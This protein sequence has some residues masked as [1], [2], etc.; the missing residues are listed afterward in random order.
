MISKDEIVKILEQEYGVT[1]HRKLSIQKID[2]SIFVL[3]AK[4]DSGQNA[5]T[6]DATTEHERS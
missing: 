4:R 1:D 6:L 2:I 5:Y 3:C